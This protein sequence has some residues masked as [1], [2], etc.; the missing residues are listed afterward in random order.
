MT[1][2]N[3]RSPSP[4]TLMKKLAAQGVATRLI[5]PDGSVLETLTADS[6]AIPLNSNKSNNP[7]DS[8]FDG[9]D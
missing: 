5:M 3:K 9:N 1:R 6:P 7:W 2:P 8:L 4:L